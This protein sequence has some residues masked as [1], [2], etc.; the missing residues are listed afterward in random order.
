MAGARNEKPGANNANALNFPYSKGE[1]Y[2]ITEAADKFSCGRSLIC[3]GTM[4]LLFRRIQ[5]LSAKATYDI[6]M[7]GK[8]IQ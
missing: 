6:T 2:S 8:I 5:Y 3:M 7:P 4:N 1:P